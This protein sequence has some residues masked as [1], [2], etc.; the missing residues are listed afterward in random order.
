MQW[1]ILESPPNTGDYLTLLIGSNW[2]VKLTDDLKVRFSHIFGL[3]G[4]AVKR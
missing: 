1:D 4:R 3:W 2:V